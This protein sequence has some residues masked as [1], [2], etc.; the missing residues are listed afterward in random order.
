MKLLLSALFVFLSFWRFCFAA[1]PLILA[2]HPFLQSDEVIEKFTPLAK[3]L[4][5]QLGTKVVIK[6]GTN[7]KEHIDYIGND[8]VDV[9]YMGPSSYVHLVDEYGA[10]PL[11]AR[12]EIDGVPSF[13][14]HIIVRNDSA[15]KSIEDLKG[16]SFAYG[17]K[18]STMSFVVPHYM[19]SQAGVVK[20]NHTE[21][22]FLGS[23]NNVALSVL[24]G[25]YDAGA[26]KPAVF[27]KYEAKGLRS[28]A[29]TPE[30]SEHL[31]VTRSNMPIKEIDK[32]RD[33]LLSSHR[34]TEGLA[35]L[36][37]IKD[38]ISRLVPVQ[39]SD[40]DN[41]RIIMKSVEAAH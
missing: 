13:H 36:K 4:E 11:L 22:T 16:K 28:I 34:S 35:A 8:M 23:H 25:D 17:D 41:L 40:Y 30:I 31:F 6:V 39:E 14:G 21:H 24:S 20:P 7:Y 9:A 37:I 26:I 32:L 29:I 27:K 15:I 12:Q 3:Y 10:K 5:S 19:L 38:D 1:D 18:E 2:V 33:E